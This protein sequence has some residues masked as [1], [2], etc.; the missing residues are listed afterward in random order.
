MPATTTAASS[1]LAR[2]WFNVQ[3]RDSLTSQTAMPVDTP[4][5]VS[6][7]SM[8]QDYTIKAGHRIGVIIGGND[9][10]YVTNITPTP[11][12]TVDLAS[13]SVTLP[14]VGYPVSQWLPEGTGFQTI[15]ADVQPGQLALSVPNALVT[16]PS[17][18]LTGYDQFVTGALNQVT[19]A[20][21]RGT[22]AGWSLTGQVSDFVGPNG[23]IL[24]DNLGWG[25]TAQSV[26]GAL[27]TTSNVE[28]VVTAGPVTTPGTGTGLAD[29][30]SLC[31]SRSGA[32]AGAFQ[33]G[34]SLNLGIP[35]ATS[36]GTYT[37]VLTL[38]LI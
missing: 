26:T 8:P 12:F 37:G 1:I 33:C 32:S 36:L 35:G 21:G 34:G 25:P 28:S 22:S 11:T 29:A 15:T 18:T 38:T 17:V 14:I 31:T 4:T 6:W 13:S 20:D 23:L 19:V 3:H 5:Q 24:A 27:P 7:A 10:S 9:S 2:G 16:L 30:K